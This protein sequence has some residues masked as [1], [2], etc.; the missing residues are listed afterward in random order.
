MVNGDQV[1]DGE[2]HIRLLR[3]PLEVGAR[4]KSRTGPCQDDGSAVVGRLSQML[5]EG[6]EELGNKRVVPLGAIQAHDENAAAELG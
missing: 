3:D 5:D 6:F 4:A 1:C 2:R